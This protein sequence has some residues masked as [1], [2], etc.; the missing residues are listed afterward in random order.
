MGGAYR[1]WDW[2]RHSCD[3]DGSPVYQAHFGLDRAPFAETV[4]PSAYVALPSRD[5][6]L[7]RLRYALDGAQ[8]AAVLYGPPGSGKTLLVRRL[9]SGRTAPAVHVTFPI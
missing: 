4:H 5:A 1:F 2:P 3:G 8:G 7:R 9:A 6:I